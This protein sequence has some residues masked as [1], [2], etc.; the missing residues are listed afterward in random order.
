MTAEAFIQSKLT[1]SSAVNLAIS[2]WRSGSTDYKMIFN[3][4]VIPSLSASSY[5]IKSTD[6]ATT[7]LIVNGKLN[8][9]VQ[10]RTVNYYR[11][12]TI[13]GFLPHKEADY[14]IN[15]RA[16][17]QAEAEALA[18]AVFSALNMVG[19][20]NHNCLCSLEVIIPPRDEQDNFNA[21]VNARIKNN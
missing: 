12:S 19:D 7:S 11:E 2:Q 16:Y 18:S 5:K 8:T 4:W 13:D 17:T 14:S 1:A 9:T 3:G 15:C 20:A 6:S 21:R 10:F